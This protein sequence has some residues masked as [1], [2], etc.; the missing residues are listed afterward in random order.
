MLDH[1]LE[2]LVRAMLPKG[3]IPSAA[4]SPAEREPALSEAE[5]NPASSKRQVDELVMY[6]FEFGG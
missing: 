2:N 1:G 6:Q 5:G 4:A 3:V